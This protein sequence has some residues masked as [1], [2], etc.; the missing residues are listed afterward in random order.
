[1]ETISAPLARTLS[2]EADGNFIGHEAAGAGEEEPAICGECG[3]LLALKHGDKCCILRAEHVG[4][5]SLICAEQ[6]P[7][8]SVR[9][10]AGSSCS[11]V[12][13]GRLPPSRA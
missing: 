2:D 13:G 7:S 12:L 8:S 9:R 5:Q 11:A 1:M 6:E 4:R 10:V 3:E